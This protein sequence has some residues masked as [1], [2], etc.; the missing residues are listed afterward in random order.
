MA[1]NSPEEMNKKRQLAKDII[2]NIF[3]YFIFF[4]I[5]MFAYQT[6]FGS[7]GIQF[8]LLAVPFFLFFII[9]RVCKNFM[10]FML[11]HFILIALPMFL[12][13]NFILM[14]TMTG[15]AIAVSVFSLTVRFVGERKLTMGSFLLALVINVTLF[16]LMETYTTGN[17]LV[18]GLLNY[19]FL[20]MLACVMLYIHLDNVDFSLTILS[21]QYRKPMNNV[22][23]HNNR[24]I[25]IFIGAVIVIGI[26]SSFLPGGFIIG[27]IAGF[28]WFFLSGLI[29]FLANIFARLGSLI[30]RTPPPA[31][32]EIETDLTLEEMA[33]LLDQGNEASIWQ[34]FTQIANIIGIVFLTVIII[35]IVLY[36][37]FT[38][39][40]KFN[41]RNIDGDEADSLMPTDV[42]TGIK[43]LFSD[44]RKML[45][46]FRNAARHPVRRAFVR[47]INTH[48]RL[49]TQI[50]PSDTP[51]K[52]C[53]KIRPKEN[54]DELTEQYEKV[55]YGA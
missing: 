45:P 29:M 28:I 33:I 9:R 24:M 50:L 3:V 32:V 36:G 26:V 14:L 46:K 40:R 5:F 44:L 19:S 16:S 35:V 27:N 4:N 20:A 10:I 18:F 11:A 21:T 25:S 22:I 7:M 31:P 53:D 15:F 34:L 39:Y 48:M 23:N 8:H 43:V 41:A 47:K 2:S 17:S 42:F 30:M 6:T 49:G 38:I 54:I 55:R 51:D 1:T 37:S 13:S 12:I 52:I